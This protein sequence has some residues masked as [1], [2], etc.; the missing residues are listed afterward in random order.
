[1]AR[2]LSTRSVLKR[3]R[4][5]G[6]DMTAIIEQSKGRIEIGHL[7]DGRATWEQR[8]ANFKLAE[9]AS[10]L[11]GWGYF[12]SGYGSVHLWADRGCPVHR[13]LVANN[14]D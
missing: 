5:G 12:G 8:E 6:F 1:M 3:L 9:Q 11:I 10:E 2:T 14:M 7:T 4:E 13:E